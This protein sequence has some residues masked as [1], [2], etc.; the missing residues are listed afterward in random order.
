MLIIFT[1]I[2]PSSTNQRWFHL[3]PTNL[4]AELFIGLPD[5]ELE[6]TGRSSG[7]DIQYRSYSYPPLENWPV[8]TGQG[9]FDRNLIHTLP[10][11]KFQSSSKL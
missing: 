6:Y 7:K 4:K 11:L 10:A 1:R 8:A 3:D 5:D 2:T 9:M